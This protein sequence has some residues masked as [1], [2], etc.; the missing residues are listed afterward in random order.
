M[1][2]NSSFPFTPYYASLLTFHVFLRSGNTGDA[3]R[4][5]QFR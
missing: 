4:L 1:R 2:T 5:K 3:R